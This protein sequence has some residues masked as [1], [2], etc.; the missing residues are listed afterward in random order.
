MTEP[1]ELYERTRREVTELVLGA[2]RERH[3]E[4]VPGCPAWSVRDAP[5]NP[6]L[7]VV[8]RTDAP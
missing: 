3:D 2:E 1:V 6:E 5:A 4:R 8:P 7:D